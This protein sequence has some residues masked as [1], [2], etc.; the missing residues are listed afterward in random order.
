MN[1]VGISFWLGAVLLLDA[2]FGLWNCERLEKVAPK[3]NL[4]RIAF[5]EVAV[6]MVL[7]A[8]SF[9]IRNAK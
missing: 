2:A 5:I 4:P 8:V 1:W 3:I 9:W 6:A 7:F